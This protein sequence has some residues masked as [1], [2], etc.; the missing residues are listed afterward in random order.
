MAEFTADDYRRV[1]RL[2]RMK[3]HLIGSPLA[4]LL[5]VPHAQERIRAVPDLA[6]VEEGETEVLVICP[7]GSHP[8]LPSEDIANALTKCPGC[9]RWYLAHGER[10]LVIYGDMPI[11]GAAGTTQA[12]GSSQD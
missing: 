12:Q 7:C 2:G 9:E 6:I 1:D 10:V 8:V 3:P 11:P 4:W 5:V